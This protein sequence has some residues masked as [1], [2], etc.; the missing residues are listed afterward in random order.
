LIVIASKGA[1]MKEGRSDEK[2]ELLLSSASCCQHPHAEFYL[3]AGRCMTAAILTTTKEHRKH[4]ALYV[5]PP[6][7]VV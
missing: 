4:G 7:E 5:V 2:R 6:L 3:K 1:G